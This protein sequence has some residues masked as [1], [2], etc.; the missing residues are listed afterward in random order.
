MKQKVSPEIKNNNN[1]KLCFYY[2][3]TRPKFG[4]SGIEVYYSGSK[5]GNQ[6]AIPGER[7]HFR[8]MCA[9]PKQ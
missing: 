8:T 7:K 3:V 5:Q 2:N 4:N 9:H 1:T 6:Q